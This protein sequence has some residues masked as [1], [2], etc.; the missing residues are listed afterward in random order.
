[1]TRKA[2]LARLTIRWQQTALVHSEQRLPP[3]EHHIRQTL[4]HHIP[5]P[6][7]RINKMVATIKTP[8][9]L[10]NHRLAT[11]L[12]KHTN[13]RRHPRPRRRTGLK[14]IHK[15]PS[16]I[17]IP[18]LIEH[19]AQK[20]AQ[21]FRIHRPVIN[22]RLRIPRSRRR[23]ARH[24]HPL[25][26]PMHWCRLLKS[27]RLHHRYHL[28][29]PRPDFTRQKPVHIQRI[30]GIHTIDHRQGVE[31]HPS[32]LHHLR[33]RH[34]PVKCRLTAFRFPVGVV[35]LLGPVNTQPHQKPV[36]LEKI[37][38]L[39][40]Q[41]CAI[42]LEIIDHALGRRTVPILKLHHLAEEIQP[43]Q[44]RLAPLPV[45]HDLHRVVAFNIG[46]DISL[47]NVLWNRNHPG[48][49]Q[50][51]FLAEIIAIVAIQITHRAE[52]L[53]HH[54]V[55]LGERSRQ[56]LNFLIIWHNAL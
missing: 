37:T 56:P 8:V 53:A 49:P 55:M 12:G 27:L 3:R 50:Q 13:L 26:I 42:R 34:H 32:L 22:H 44:C 24:R 28:H 31:H 33:R 30:P 1:M 16:D 41:Q 14:Q 23:S 47:Q 45:K 51:R 15:M 21:L 40:I 17:S 46:A 18:P 2:I 39:L 29:Q 43:E 20:R 52:R 54:A 10:K 19:P 9:A 5:Q 7:F 38:P 48:V 11:Y 36:P 25:H 6:V 35:K 4:L